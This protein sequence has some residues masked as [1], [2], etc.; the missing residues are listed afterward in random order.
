MARVHPQRAAAPPRPQPLACPIA[1][2]AESLGRPTTLRHVL[3]LVDVP[4]LLILLFA[5]HRLL[6]HFSPASRA[7][8]ERL[9]SARA[10]DE[11]AVVVEGVAVV[12]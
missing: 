2:L 4:L 3:L 8:R 7:E 6:A 11:A 1:R 5:F 9:R 12:V 10:R